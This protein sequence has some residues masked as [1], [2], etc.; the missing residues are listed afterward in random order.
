M[1]PVS[2]A[3]L[4]AFAQIT[5]AISSAEGAEK[6]NRLKIFTIA[7]PPLDSR[8]WEV[9]VFLLVTQYPAISQFMDPKV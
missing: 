3:T 4:A 2:A 7:K 1:N 8:R 6:G 5:T 9:K